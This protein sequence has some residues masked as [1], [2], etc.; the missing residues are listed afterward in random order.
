MAIDLP[1]LPRGTKF[2]P[3]ILR[4][5]GDLPGVLGGPTTRVTR[6]GSRFAFDVEL[7]TLEAACASK[8]VAARLQADTLGQTLRMAVPQ[9]GKGAL[10]GAP[11]AA[12][13]A[14]NSASLT[15]TGGGAVAVGMFFSFAAGGRTYLHMVTSVAGNLL[16]VA[17]LLRASPVGQVLNFAAPV[18]EGFV[19]G[20]SW[21]IERL[22]FV[23]Q[24][25]S[26]SED[27]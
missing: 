9:N 24:S 16:G 8:L 21:S 23:S 19:D 14:V 22:R 2:S 20:A 7:P 5:G 10:A 27:R 11:V 6:L 17:P 3:R 13:G 1:A 12:S 25:F 26:L 4:F 18:V 15:K